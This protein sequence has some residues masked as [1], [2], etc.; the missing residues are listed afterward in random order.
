MY[1]LDFIN[2][3]TDQYHQLSQLVKVAYIKKLP[4]GEY[5]VLSTKGRNLGTYPT[6]EEAEERLQ[7]VEMFKHLKKKKLKKKAE[8][9]LDLTKIEAFSLSSIMRK[10]NKQLGQK[11]CHQ[12]AAIYKK[13]F[14][15]YVTHKDPKAEEKS[16]QETVVEFNQQHPLDINSKF[17]KLAAAPPQLGDPQ[18]VGKYL[19]NIIRFTL[20]RI[21]PQS[22]PG[23]IN[24][25]KHKIYNLNDMEIS[26]KKMPPASSMGQ[27]ITFVKHVLFGQDPKYVRQVI[28]YI[29]RS[30]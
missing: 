24:K 21:S 15:H 22:R 20:N 23:S 12:F 7:M 3:A 29:V 30:L 1:T 13:K 9:K 25:M 28:N 26:Q 6:K 16:L 27:A 10:I 14:D 19:A 11:A 5:R 17:V 4:S 18:L 8:K 2:H